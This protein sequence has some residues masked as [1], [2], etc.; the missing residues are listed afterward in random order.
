MRSLKHA[1]ATLLSSAIVITFGLASA[2]AAP[3]N[4]QIHVTG[5]IDWGVKTT[6]VVN[7]IATPKGVSGH[8]TYTFHLG[9]RPYILQI[10]PKCMDAKGDRGYVAGTV[11]MAQNLEDFF[12]EDIT[13]RTG[14]IYARNDDISDVGGRSTDLIINTRDIDVQC[15]R[16]DYFLNNEPETVDFVIDTAAAV[17]NTN[18]IIKV[19]DAS[20][21]VVTIKK[22]AN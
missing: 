11:T 21:I 3:K 12:G 22:K 6:F 10:D 14:L 15:D 7:A 20:N 13:G 9:N 1:K 8:M 19:I 18:G 16:L 17:E 5:Q 2:S 4:N